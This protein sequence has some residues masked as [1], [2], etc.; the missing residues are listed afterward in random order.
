MKRVSSA[1]LQYKILFKVRESY[2]L[3]W[4]SF[5]VS[6]RLLGVCTVGCLTQNEV[7]M[8]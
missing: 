2:V 8:L 6:L 5:I 1:A 7:R 3:C 4:V